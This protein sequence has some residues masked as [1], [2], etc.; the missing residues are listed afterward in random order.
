MLD[1]KRYLEFLYQTTPDRYANSR[2]ECGGAADNNYQT[3]RFGS[4]EQHVM[5]IQ[6]W[7]GVAPT[8]ARGEGYLQC[9]EL[10][11]LSC[12]H[13][14]TGGR[15]VAA[16]HL[17]GKGSARRWPLKLCQE[18]FCCGHSRQ[19]WRALRPPHARVK[20]VR[21]AAADPFRIASESQF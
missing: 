10:G 4:G 8:R 16:H 21:A 14:R 17:P 19:N 5:P 6:T 13:T 12:A 7:I 9:S 3:V 20:V 1:N 11:W 18:N 15:F 2:F